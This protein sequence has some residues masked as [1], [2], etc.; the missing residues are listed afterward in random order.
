M[1]INH[2]S[3]IHSSDSTQLKDV[4]TGRAVTRPAR[5]L[6]T[7]LGPAEL[8]LYRLRFKLY[9]LAGHGNG[10]NQYRLVSTM[11]ITS[12]LAQA[13]KR[14]ASMVTGYACLV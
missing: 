12:W 5:T 6:F 11:R 8:L 10:T 4:K 14:E 3:F 7:T 1:S 13:R 2:V 9:R